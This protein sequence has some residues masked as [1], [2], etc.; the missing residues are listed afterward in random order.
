MKKDIM[1][2]WVK[3]LRSGEF[4][5]GGG[6]LYKDGNYCCL[7]VLCRLHARENN[8]RFSGEDVSVDKGAKKYLG[9]ADFPQGIVVKWAGLFLR[10]PRDSIGNKLSV[11]N[12]DRECTFGEIAD[13]IESDYKEL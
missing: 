13:I 5:Q 2:R 3:A 12:D 6:A 9:K 1:K 10:D 7:G 11:Y 8:K 4:K